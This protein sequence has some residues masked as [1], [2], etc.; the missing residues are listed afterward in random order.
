MCTWKHKTNVVCDYAHTNVEPCSPSMIDVAFFVALPVPVHS[1]DCASL[2]VAWVA[3]R[4][5]L[6]SGKSEHRFRFGLKS[7][8]KRDLLVAVSVSN[9]SQGSGADKDAAV[10]GIPAPTTQ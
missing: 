7:L 10:L 5:S 8:A 4:C 3:D 9:S 1:L 6:R 2:T